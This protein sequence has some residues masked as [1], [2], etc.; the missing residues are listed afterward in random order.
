VGAWAW[1]C[2]ADGVVAAKL[3]IFIWSV[4]AMEEL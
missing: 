1:A 3:L 2:V 4:R